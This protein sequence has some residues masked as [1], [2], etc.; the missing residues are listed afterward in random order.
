MLYQTG[1]CSTKV[2]LSAAGRCVPG[3]WRLRQILYASVARLLLIRAARLLPSVGQALGRPLAGAPRELRVVTPGTL[4]CTTSGREG[5]WEE[6]EKP[7]PHGGVAEI[8]CSPSYL[9]KNTSSYCKMGASGELQCISNI[10]AARL[11]SSA[12]T[13][14]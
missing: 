7:E 1:R 10:A 8:C 13:R 11:L 9:G 4:P 12:G 2:G 5:G 14:T 3:A 6:S